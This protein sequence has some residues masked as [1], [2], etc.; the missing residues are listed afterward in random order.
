MAKPDVRIEILPDGTVRLGNVCAAARWAGVSPQ[1]FADTVRRHIRNRINGGGC[2]PKG[3]TPRE[4]I[5]A[6]YPELF[7]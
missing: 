1:T 6:T 5:L 7:K 4:K 2:K 3:L